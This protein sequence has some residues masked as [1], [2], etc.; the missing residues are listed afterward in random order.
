MKAIK[1]NKVYTV[2]ETSKKSYLSQGYDIVDDSGKLLEKSPSATVS[3]SKYAAVK[4]E[5]DKLKS[6]AEIDKIKSE[7]AKK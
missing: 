6:E 4:A 7:N 1:G 3:Y 5:L 2:D